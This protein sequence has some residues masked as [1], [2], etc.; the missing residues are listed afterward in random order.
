MQNPFT[1]TVTVSSDRCGP[2]GAVRLSHLLRLQHDAADCQLTG[3]GLQVDALLAHGYAFILSRICV[4]THRL[5]RAGERITVRT[6]PRNTRGIQ[7][8]RCFE[9]YGEDGSL[10]TESVAAYALLDTATHTVQRPS[11]LEAIAVIPDLGLSGGCPDPVRRLPD[12]PTAPVGSL[13]IPA[14]WID[15]NGHMNNAYYADILQDFIPDVYKNRPVTGFQ[16]HYAHEILAEQT[17]EVFGGADGNTV[18]VRGIRGDVTCFEG[19]LTVG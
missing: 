13:V 8:F 19:V 12:I 7:F 9:I 10:L 3:W 14:A 15:W 16:L 4:Q 11:V 1:H 18:S 6:W 2:D 5:P 17:M